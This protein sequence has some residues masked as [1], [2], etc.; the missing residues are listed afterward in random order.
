MPTGIDYN[1]GNLK[2]I[3]LT[4]PRRP[5]AALARTNTRPPLQIPL[6][7]HTRKDRQSHLAR[8]QNT[9]AVKFGCNP[10]KTRVFSLTLTPPHSLQMPLRYEASQGFA[11]AHV[12]P[13]NQSNL[14]F[15][16]AVV[17]VAHQVFDLRGHAQQPQ[18]KPDFSNKT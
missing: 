7:I 3:F 17:R 11:R 18:L 13:H 6:R 16:H 15:G 8:D 9:R 10:Q 2:F 5:S 14:F 4:A 1:S 12:V